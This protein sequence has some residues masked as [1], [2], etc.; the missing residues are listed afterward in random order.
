MNILYYFTSNW[1]FD[2]VSPDTKFLT[3]FLHTPPKI[4]NNPNCSCNETVKHFACNNVRGVW[5]LEDFLRKYKF[6]A[7]ENNIAQMAW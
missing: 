1:D 4:C 2:Y 5:N 6:S 3:I 7:G